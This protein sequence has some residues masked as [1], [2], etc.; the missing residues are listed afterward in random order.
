MNDEQ[1]NTL[2]REIVERLK[3]VEQRLDNKQAAEK[4]MSTTYAKSQELWLADHNKWKR[5]DTF[6]GITRVLAVLLL[7]YIAY[8]V[9]H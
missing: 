4:E 3:S 7:A 6:L 1:S 8:R 5:G 2:L 9:S